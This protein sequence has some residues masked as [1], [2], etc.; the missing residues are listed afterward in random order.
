[1]RGPFLKVRTSRPS[2]YGAYPGGPLRINER[3]Y[4]TNL[5]DG[6]KQPTQ[7]ES[8]IQPRACDVLDGLL[9]SCLQSWQNTSSLKTKY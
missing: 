2:Q 8:N 9:V 1:M 4:L 3:K 5:S 6:G 7:S